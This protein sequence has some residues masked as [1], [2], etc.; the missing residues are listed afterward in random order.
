MRPNS[1]IIATERNDA[2]KEAAK[3]MFVTDI[4]QTA[5]RLPRLDTSPA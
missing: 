4:P 1:D 5:H 3:I 2:E